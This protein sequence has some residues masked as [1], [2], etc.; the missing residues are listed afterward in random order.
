MPRKSAVVDKQALRA[1]REKEIAKEQ[2][3]AQFLEEMRLLR[4]LRAFCVK[5]DTSTLDHLGLFRGPGLPVLDSGMATT[6]PTTTA[7]RTAAG[8]ARQLSSERN[9]PR[10]L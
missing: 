6:C 1:E 3:K 7:T 9:A 10:P 8:G 2:E 4:P 5:E